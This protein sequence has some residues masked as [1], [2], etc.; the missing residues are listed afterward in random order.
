[1]D[2][3]L[4]LDLKGDW[5]QCGGLSRQFPGDQEGLWWKAVPRFPFPLLHFEFSS[6]LPS[7]FSPCRLLY[8]WDRLRERAGV[9]SRL[10]PQPKLHPFDFIVCVDASKWVIHIYLSRMEGKKTGP[11]ARWGKQGR[12][13]RETDRRVL[14]TQ[15]HRTGLS[16]LPFDV[17]KHHVAC[18]ALMV[19][20][21]QSDIAL[22]SFFIFELALCPG[23]FY[24]LVFMLGVPRNRCFKNSLVVRYTLYFSVKTCD[25]LALMILWGLCYYNSLARVS[26]NSWSSHLSLPCTGIIGTHH[27]S[28][29]FINLFKKY[30]KPHK[31]LN[32]LK[33]YFVPWSLCIFNFCIFMSVTISF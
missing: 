6:S 19:S 8:W 23:G 29:V 14:Q 21:K 5:D 31:A 13:T 1:M 30:N 17:W 22:D 3:D 25:L 15:S 27:Y 33:S 32:C 7:F 18:P 11:G 10:V 24:T 9:S 2:N 4:P 20:R 16:S 12:N 28:S 26:S